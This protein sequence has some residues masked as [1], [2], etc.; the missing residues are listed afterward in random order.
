MSSDLKY[1]NPTVTEAV[2]EFRFL[3][4]G[5]WD[6]TIPGLVFHRLSALFPTK[7][8]TKRFRVGGRADGPEFSVQDV[9]R[10]QH[11]DHAERA[12][13]QI[14][15]HQLSVHHLA[16]YLGWE[17]FRPLICEAWQAYVDE[18][19]PTGYQRLGLRYINEIEPPSPSADFSEY[20]EIYPH[21]GAS[22]PQAIGPWEMVVNSEVESDSGMDHLRIRLGAKNPSLERLA[23]VLDLD[24]AHEQSGSV[25]VGDGL[26]WIDAAHERVV[27]YFDSCL[28]SQT[29]ERLGRHPSL[30]AR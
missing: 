26:G 22:L 6:A 29:K 4:T 1:K 13:V 5:P 28:T 23:S 24:Y 25:E 7:V 8:T 16:P 27:S 14:S 9:V 2:C 15:T 18:A 20:L 21:V 19:N 12:F 3:A 17:V 10:L 11:R 30:A